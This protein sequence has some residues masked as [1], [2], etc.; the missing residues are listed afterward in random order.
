MTL[1]LAIMWA[2]CAVHYYDKTTGTENLWGFGHLK[3]KI[4]PPNEGIQGVVQG[5][6]MFG[7]NIGAGQ[8]EY[9]FSFGWDSCRKIT[10]S[11]NAMVRLEWPNAD[12]FRVRL[13]TAPPWET[14]EIK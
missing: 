11:S 10:M 6:A 14:N 1:W 13:G 8:D 5:S 3:M 4:I 2:G 12:F 9:H 7:L